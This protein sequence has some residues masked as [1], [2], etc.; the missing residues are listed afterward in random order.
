MTKE[1]KFATKQSSLGPHCNLAI[2]VAPVL[3]EENNL[4]TNDLDASRVLI[5]RASRENLNSHQRCEHM[6]SS[7]NHSLS[8]SNSWKKVWDYK[9][10]YKKL[11]QQN[12]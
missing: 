10:G 6:T 12:D 4:L 9:P 5:A 1:T 8:A 3:M 11:M 7:R 2:M